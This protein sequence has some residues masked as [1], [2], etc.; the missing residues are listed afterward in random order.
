MLNKIKNQSHTIPQIT[1]HGTM[2]FIEEN[3]Y[4]II[5]NNKKNNTFTL[6]GEFKIVETNERVT[7]KLEVDKQHI[8]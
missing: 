2:S 3:V 1:T 5:N 7:L 4:E 6:L 8:K